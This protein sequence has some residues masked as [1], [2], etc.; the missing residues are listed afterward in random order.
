[1]PKRRTEYLNPQIGEI[2][3]FR[4]TRDDE[5]ELIP[6]LVEQRIPSG[7]WSDW[8]RQ[9]LRE[10]MERQR[11]PFVGVEPAD[12]KAAVLHIVTVALDA[13]DR[14]PIPESGAISIGADDG[15]LKPLEECARRL[16][17]DD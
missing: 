4:L 10:K 13:Q 14:L 12:V 5:A 3:A 2:L 11:N 17:I 6:W 7:G 15:R 9:L 16:F 1:M 8:I